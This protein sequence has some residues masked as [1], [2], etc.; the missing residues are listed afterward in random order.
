MLA[1][2]LTITEMRL[3]VCLL[4]HH[5]EK[6]SPDVFNPPEFG[7][8]WPSTRLLLEV[9]GLTKSALSRAKAG[10]VKKGILRVVKVGGTVNFTPKWLAGSLTLSS[11][12]RQLKVSSTANSPYKDDLIIKAG[13]ERAHTTATLS[14]QYIN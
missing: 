8:C 14:P 5:N 4:A 13:S 12:P 7:C 11:Q 6:M 2:N 3:A 9:L 1:E 10:L